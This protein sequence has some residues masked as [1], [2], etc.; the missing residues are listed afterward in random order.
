MVVGKAPGGGNLI[1]GDGNGGTIPPEV[2]SDPKA[3]VSNQKL[4]GMGEP[5][6]QEVGF[7]RAARMFFLI[8]SVIAK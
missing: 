7:G 8:N 2:I 4:S 6:V 1:V 3:G 5:A